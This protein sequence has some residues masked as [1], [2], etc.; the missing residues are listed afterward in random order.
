MYC[1]RAALFFLPCLS[2]ENHEDDS[3]AY[4]FHDIVSI[5]LILPRFQVP[6]MHSYRPLMIALNLRTFPVRR[7]AGR[8]RVMRWTDKQLTSALPASATRSSSPS[9]RHMNRKM[10]QRTHPDRHQLPLPM[11]RLAAVPQELKRVVPKVEL[12]KEK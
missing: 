9:H 1:G 3:N 4:L 5:L 10:P 7:L 11:L 12:I 2:V 8:R 6:K